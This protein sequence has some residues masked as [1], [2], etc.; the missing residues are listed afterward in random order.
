M[1]LEQPFR[2]YLEL[3]PRCLAAILQRLELLDQSPS[4]MQFSKG[5]LDSVASLV[6]CFDRANEPTREAIVN[7]L[8]DLVGVRAVSAD[9]ERQNVTFRR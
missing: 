5:S 6:L 9:Y 3:R 2:V 1:C 4:A 7:W 8:K